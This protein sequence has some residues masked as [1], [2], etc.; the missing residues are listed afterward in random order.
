VIRFQKLLGKWYFHTE[1]EAN[2]FT[3]VVEV[4]ADLSGEGKEAISE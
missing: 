1:G 2:I 4:A 3:K